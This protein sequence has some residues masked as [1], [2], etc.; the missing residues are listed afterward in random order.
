MKTISFQV[1]SY[2]G[3]DLVASMLYSGKMMAKRVAKKVMR[4]GAP[5][6]DFEPGP[7]INLVLIMP[8]MAYRITDV[9]GSVEPFK[10]ETTRIGL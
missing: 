4:D 3:I 5:F 2:T 7:D 6:A 1:R 10:G 9:D 8:D